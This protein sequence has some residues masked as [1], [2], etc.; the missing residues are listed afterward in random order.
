MKR[1][2]LIFITVLVS[3][4]FI[5]VDALELNINSNNAVLYNLKDNTVLY[6]K[7]S[8][9]KVSI[10]SLTKI[11]TAIVA[12]ENIDNLDE[13]VVIK[14]ADF[15][16]I[17]EANL[18]TAGF[19]IGDKV[20]YRDLLYGLLFPSGAEAAQALANNISS[21]NEEFVKLM[22]K[23]KDELKLKNT[24]FANTTG[25]DNEN[26]YSTVK[27]V[28][29]IFKYA[30]KNKEFLKIITTKTYQVSNGSFSLK[31]PVT[32]HNLGMNYLLGGK[33]GTTGDAGL[34]LATIAKQDDAYLMLVTVKAPYTKS[35]P[36]A[37]LDAKTVYDYFFDNYSYHEVVNKDDV[38]LKLKTLYTKDD[39]V[40][41]KANK[42][43]KLYLKNNY[44]KKDIKYKYKGTKIVT[45]KMKKGE[46][47]GVLN[48]YYK[49]KKVNSFNVVL[50]QNQ[51]LSINKY[52][53]GH[54]LIVIAVL[55][56]FIGLLILLKCKSKR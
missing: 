2:I 11:M 46:K 15:D 45:Y 39:I 47:L 24:H 5:D 34:C 4:L 17:A 36:L 56:V 54:K 26:H 44:N 22:N 20:T 55:V 8:D 7:N 35:K 18:A 13:T 30:L 49:N 42:S 10:A 9:E 33:T 29:T 38:V 14:K 27:D 50:N 19:K 25:L 32:K 43:I 52:L 40:K 21:S 53:L 51:T 48:I 37:Y 41:F 6:E 31:S 3:V 16:G 23:K 12:I 28:A 1:L